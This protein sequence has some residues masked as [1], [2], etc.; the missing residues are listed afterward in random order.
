MK[1]IRLKSGGSVYIIC[2][3]DSC[4]AGEICFLEK[5]YALAQKL[6]ASYSQDPSQQKDFWGTTLDKKR[7][8]PGYTLFQDF[9]DS[10]WQSIC[11]D[12]MR[13]LAVHRKPKEIP[14]LFPSEQSEE[15]KSFSDMLSEVI[16]LGGHRFQLC[17]WPGRKNIDI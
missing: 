11:G 1:P 10:S 2:P 4:P 5:E 17:L 7:A 12:I 13:M 8:I 9:P 6:S 15:L 14:G 16:D 3:G